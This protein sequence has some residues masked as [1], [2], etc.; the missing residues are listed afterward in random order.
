MLWSW[1]RR[2]HREGLGRYQPAVWSV[3]TG[4]GGANLPVNTSVEGGFRQMSVLGEALIVN[5]ED[6]MCLRIGLGYLSGLQYARVAVRS[7]DEV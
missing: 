2:R 1:C 3:F 6:I 5:E 7:S 4:E